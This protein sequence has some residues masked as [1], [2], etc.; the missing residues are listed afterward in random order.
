MMESVG[1][2]VFRAM[3]SQ[4]GRQIMRGVLGTIMKSR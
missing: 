3:G 4:A 1:K 2:S